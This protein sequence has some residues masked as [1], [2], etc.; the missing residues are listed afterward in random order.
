PS[1]ALGWRARVASARRPRRKTMALVSRVTEHAGTA[2]EGGGAPESAEG[3]AV[4]E[5]I[6]VLAGAGEEGRRAE[7]LERLEAGT[8]ARGAV[9]AAAGGGQGLAALPAAGAGV[10]VG[11]RGAARAQL[12]R[13]RC[14]P[15]RMP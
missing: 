11:D 12:A 6:L 8:D 15:P 4:L 7:L 3:A 2:L 9:L 1:T 10:R 13:D 5:R 14:R